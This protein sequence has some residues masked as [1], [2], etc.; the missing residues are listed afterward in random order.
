MAGRTPAINCQTSNKAK[1][2]IERLGLFAFISLWKK[3]SD[4]DAD[5][6]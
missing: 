4:N 6:F 3:L 1:G 2:P 5:A